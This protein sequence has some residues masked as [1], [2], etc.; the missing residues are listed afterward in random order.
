MENK[1]QQNPELLKIIK[2]QTELLRISLH[3]STQGPTTYAGEELRCNLNQAKLKTSQLIAMSAGQ[4]VNTILKC[5]EW[6]GIPVR[7][8]YPVARST[9]ESF[10]NAAFLLVEDDSVAQ[11]AERYVA[12]KAWKQL[13]RKVGSGDFSLQISMPQSDKYAIPSEF[14]EFDGRG[15]EGWTKLD[16]SSRFHR[17]GELAGKKAGSRLL[18]AYS[19]VYSLSSEIIHGSPYGVNYFYQA[20]LPANPTI[21]DFQI[22]TAKQ[23]EDLLVAISHAVA[24]YLAAFFKFQGM[25]APYI[26]EQELF[27]RLLELESVEPQEIERLERKTTPM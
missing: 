22:S 9:I 11:R 27:N 6:K 12:F 4:S 21:E 26:A 15:N 20:H 16:L 13:N 14:A 7:D 19:L 10:I 17:V 18:A 8:L 1:Q 24:G 3:L 23:V 2:A 25:S 5:A